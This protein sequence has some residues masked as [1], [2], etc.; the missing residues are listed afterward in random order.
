MLIGYAR[1]LTAEQGLEVQ[2]DALRK[3]GCKQ[4]FC[5]VASGSLT[6]WPGLQ[7][8]LQTVREGDTLVV[9]NVDRLGRSIRHLT[10]TFTALKLRKVDLRSL[11]ES[12]PP[13][14]SP[15]ISHSV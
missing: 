15:H 1:V 5:D 11:D 12:Q 6:E 4:I 8:A 2:K 9:S 3:A 14:A 13:A 10:E 7:E